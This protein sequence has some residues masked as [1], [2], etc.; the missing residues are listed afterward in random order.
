MKLPTRKFLLRVIIASLSITAVLGIIS[1]L[2]T[3]LGETGAKIL[4]SAIGV[5]VAS[6]LT[7]CCAGPAKSASHRAVQ[8]TGILS[9]CLGVVTGLYVIWW[10]V[11]A[12]GLEGGMTRTAVVLFLLAAAS[13]H[14]SGVLVWRTYN[15][16]MRIVAPATI[17]CIAAAAELIANYVVFPGFDPGSAYLRALTAVLILD[18][19]GTILLLL[20][21]RFGPPPS[22]AAATGTTV[23]HPSPDPS[24]VTLPAVL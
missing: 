12:S 6:V 8:V 14:A 11:P 20:L 17:L 16:P 7:L 19:L 22:D 18:A 21:H 3:G 23:R 13:A 2:W 9:A 1:V 24:D 5:D 15:R 10:A 4:G